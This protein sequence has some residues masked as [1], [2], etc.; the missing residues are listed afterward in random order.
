M[1]TSIIAC[2]L[3]DRR[4]SYYNN[5]K[6]ID[7][8]YFIK[9]QLLFHNIF[10]KNK[11]N[12]ILFVIN[13]SYDD[14]AEELINEIKKLKSKIYFEVIFRDNKNF[15][16]GAWDAGI[17][18]EIFNN[19]NSDYFLLL[20]DDYVPCSE[21]TCNYFLNKI[22]DNV[23]VVCS[24]YSK[25]DLNEEHAAISNCFV[26]KNSF[27]ITKNLFKKGFCLNNGNNYSSAQDNQINFLKNI[28]K[29]FNILDLSEECCFPFYDLNYN[30]ILFYGNSNKEQIIFPLTN[31]LIKFELIENNSELNE[32][33]KFVND[34]RNNY[35]ELYLHDSKKYSLDETFNWFYTKNPKY[36][37]IKV[38]NKKVGYFRTS[39]SC[40]IDKKISIGADIHPDYSGNNIAYF[41]YINFINYL[42]YELNY[43]KIN[44]EV[45]NTN[46]KA[47]N[48][49]KKLNFETENV[50]KILKNGE[51][52]D[53]ICMTLLKSNW[54]NFINNEKIDYMT[55]VDL[56][57]FF[58]K[59]TGRRRRRGHL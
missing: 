3:G 56:P 40:E 17:E 54:K 57:E 13:L 51:Y 10:L 38:F 20:E 4:S 26:T 6:K 42:F 58:K 53:S 18:N 23:G 32:N 47:I 5:I 21:N 31:E 28:K 2:W 39:E 49:Y 48:L 7:K 25:I 8:F 30:K 52:I 22:T 55:V 27:I 44:L 43:E 35:C 41:A 24:L 33:L 36:F 46:L 16:Y 37:L 50:K 59:T 19:T 45:L 1:I 29:N 15:S 11:I 34:I 9:M 14:S 12:K